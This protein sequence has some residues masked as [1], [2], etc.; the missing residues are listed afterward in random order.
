M[1]SIHGAEERINLARESV[2]QLNYELETVEA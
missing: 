1:Y 2:A